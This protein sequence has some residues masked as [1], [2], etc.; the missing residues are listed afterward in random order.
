MTPADV[1]KTKIA[2]SMTRR[3]G[4]KEFTNDSGSVD[5]FDEAVSFDQ[6]NEGAMNTTEASSSAVEYELEEKVQEEEK[7]HEK[8]REEQQPH[9]AESQ[10]VV[11]V[12]HHEQHVDP[13]KANVRSV[14]HLRFDS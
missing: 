10:P 7:E 14:F 13:V 3:I 5:S 1:V 11:A 6:E 12:E 4:D 8:E 9:V 2:N